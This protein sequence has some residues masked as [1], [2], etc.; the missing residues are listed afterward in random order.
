MVP[1]HQP[2]TS[3]SLLLHLFL[4]HAGSF[5]SFALIHIRPDYLSNQS[6]FTSFLAW[7]QSRSPVLALPFSFLQCR[8][9]SFA[10][11]LVRYPCRRQPVP[12]SCTF[13]LT[14]IDGQAAAVKR[15]IPHKALSGF[16][17]LNTSDSV[18]YPPSFP[19]P[20]PASPF[21]QRRRVKEGAA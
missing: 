12:Q 5:L 4:R 20:Q 15:L 9:I 14:T 7:L 8:G 3:H 10:D 19:P 16:P 17:F 2:L 18:Q 21:V 1:S 13:T 11:R 6:I